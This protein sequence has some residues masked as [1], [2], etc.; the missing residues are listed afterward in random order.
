[1]AARV[2]RSNPVTD[3]DVLDGRKLLEIDCLD[4]IYLSLSVPNLVVGGQMGS[5]LTQD[6]RK[7]VPSTA[8]LE[9]GGQTFRRAVETL[10]A[11]R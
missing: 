4:R 6:E 2:S 3:N 8:L 7:P 5:F 10:L 11:I 1:M 9:R